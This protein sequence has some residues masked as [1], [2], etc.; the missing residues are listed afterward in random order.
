MT[1]RRRFYPNAWNLGNG[2]EQMSRFLGGMPGDRKALVPRLRR[3]GN[4]P[5]AAPRR[6]EF[7]ALSIAWRMRAQ[8]AFQ[9]SP[10]ANPQA[11]EEV[12]LQNLVHFD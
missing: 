7:A 5:L 9:G 4:G 10:F 1:A 6:R 8:C 12:T 3:R 2:T 11:G